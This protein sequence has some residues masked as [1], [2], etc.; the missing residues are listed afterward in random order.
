MI[1]A[2]II[3]SRVSCDGVSTIISSHEPFFATTEVIEGRTTI[4]VSFDLSLSLNK[5]V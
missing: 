4:V 2:P 3:F 1:G 5:V